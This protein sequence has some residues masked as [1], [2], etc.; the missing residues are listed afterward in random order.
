MTTSLETA[1]AIHTSRPVVDGHN[2]LPWAL[3]KAGHLDLGGIDLLETQPSLHTDIPRLIRGGVGVQFWSVWV[4]ASDPTPLASTLEQIDLVHRITDRYAEHLAMA[5]TADEARA[6]AAT[7]KVAGLIGAEGGH[8]IE[9]DLDALGRFHD[10]GVRYM[11]LTHTRTI[12]WADSATDE[13]RH[14][15]LSPWGRD[16]VREMNRLGMAV[17]VAHVSVDTMRDALDTSEAPVMSSHSSAYAIAPHPRN[18]P[19]DVLRRIGESDGIVMVCF[20][21]P[22]V[23]PDTARR[24]VE[25]LEVEQRMRRA[26]VS[27]TEINGYHDAEWERDPPDLGTV[28]TVAD[29]IEHI[30]EVAGVEHVGLGSDFDGMS[31]APVGLE[32]VSKIPNLTAELLDRGWSEP[33][34]R[35]VL[36]ENALRVLEAVEQTARQIAH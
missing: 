7:G 32:D 23:V 36:G 28:A 30:S 18:I 24:G 35:K 20:Y 3:R 4:P 25:I 16:V 13:A 26:G 5:K 19:D 17:D 8:S 34:V 1:R 9:N 29:H 10:L 14:G 21:P 2:D 11:T 33:D 31:L 27:E 22:F 15:G 12:D 6:I